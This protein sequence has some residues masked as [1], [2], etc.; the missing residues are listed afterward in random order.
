MPTLLHIIFKS[1]LA[2]VI[3]LDGSNIPLNSALAI[4]SWLPHNHQLQDCHTMKFQF[5]QR[6]PTKNSSLQHSRIACIPSCIR[7][8]SL[9]SLLHIHN[10]QERS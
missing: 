6:A 7:K 5:L 9:P 4:S 2:A 10:D 1:S 3:R 8:S